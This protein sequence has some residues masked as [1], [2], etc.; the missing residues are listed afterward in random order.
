M[1]AVT[2]LAA[3]GRVA[4]ATA[5][6]TPTDICQNHNDQPLI[7]LLDL[8]NR[9]HFNNKIKA[10]IRWEVPSIRPVVTHCRTTAPLH[11]S[12]AT[13]FEQAKILLAR[14]DARTALP[15]LIHCAD[16]G[17]REAHQLLNHLLIRLNDPRWPVYAK[18]YNR[19][20]ITAQPVPAACYYPETRLIAIHPYLA[21][22]KAPVSVLKYLVFHECCHQLVV[23]DPQQ[24]HPAE[25]MQLEM[26]APGRQRTLAWLD[27]QGFPTLPL[28]HGT[29]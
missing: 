21:E 29:T 13:D 11:P 26:R 22:R 6:T 9:R 20:C 18:R 15:L 12:L 8:V 2:A 25:F 10:G 14:N 4:T 28:M 3:T 17:H 5:D 23:C 27:K 16:N 1:T 7:R 19:A 24:P